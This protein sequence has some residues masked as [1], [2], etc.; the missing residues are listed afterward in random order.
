MLN[1]KVP[2]DLNEQCKLN[3]S[4]KIPGVFSVRDQL[5]FI[6]MAYKDLERKRTAL[7][8]PSAQCLGGP[9]W[10]NCLWLKE[11]MTW[12]EARWK[13][14]QKHPLRD[15]GRKSNKN[16]NR[17]QRASVVCAQVW[18]ARVASWPCGERYEMLQQRAELYAAK[19]L[20]GFPE[21][22][23]QPIKTAVIPRTAGISSYIFLKF[24]LGLN[25]WL[26]CCI[27]NM[28]LPPPSG[29]F[30]GVATYLREVPLY[31]KEPK[32]WISQPPREL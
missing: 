18:T 7:S 31:I 8:R 5:Q 3:T 2:S 10:Q 25:F 6:L 24:N 13:L 19:S 15:N 32:A 29:K 21:N 17:D 26:T 1:I 20:P 16:G 23:E 14:W 12:E 22:T 9:E 30:V 28:Y 27:S 4:H 11:Q